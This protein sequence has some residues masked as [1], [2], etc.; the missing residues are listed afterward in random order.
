MTNTRKPEPQFLLYIP[1]GN[2]THKYSVIYMEKH[3]KDK[4][5]ITLKKEP[6]RKYEEA[7][8]GC[9]IGLRIL[10]DSEEP[11]TIKEVTTIYIDIED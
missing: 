4:L 11:S 1:E 9:L 5:Y 10:K 2:A 8:T 7:M 6:R 3:G